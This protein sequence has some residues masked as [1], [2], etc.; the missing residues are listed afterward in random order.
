VIC[1]RR[2]ADPAA[3][4]TSVSL[5]DG[6]RLAYAAVNPSEGFPVIYLHGAIG[7]PRWRTPLLDAIVT[8]LGIRYLVVFRPGFAGSDQHRGRTVADFACDVEQ[9][10]KTLGH[11]RFGV[12]GVSAG[13]PYALACAWALPGRVVVAAAASPLTPPSGLGGC[14]TVRY[15]IPG[16]GF[17][18]PLVGPF[19]AR[20]GL[21]MLGAGTTA[22]VA[23]I[24]DYEVCRRPWGFDPGE[25]SVPVTLW[26]GVKD[27]LVPTADALRLAAALPVCTTHLEPGRGHFFFRGRAAE[28]I[29]TVG[30][31]ARQTA[32]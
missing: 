2:R 23:M 10:V 14:A 31:P 1:D 27:R 28:I 16:I 25:V 21:R 17:R 20:A 9:L 18:A 7:S 15:Q 11:D 6:R 22:P 4:A 24:E 12:V 30:E 29:E 8:R 32:A 19:A 26:H 13:A 5:G 3:D